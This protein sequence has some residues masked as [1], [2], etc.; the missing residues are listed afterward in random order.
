[1]S[2]KQRVKYQK[3]IK[4]QM[5][6]EQDRLDGSIDIVEVAKDVDNELINFM[7]KFTKVGG[8]QSIVG[9][10]GPPGI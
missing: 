5:K 8:D 2:K 9:K 10:F 1:M 7:D 4:Q 3:A 6:E